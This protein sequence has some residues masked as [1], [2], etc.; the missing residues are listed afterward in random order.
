[1]VIVVASLMCVLAS[2]A[3]YDLIINT[4][5]HFLLNVSLK[6]KTIFMNRSEHFLCPLIDDPLAHASVNVVYLYTEGVSYIFEHNSSNREIFRKYF[7]RNG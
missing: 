2:A 4:V 6:N 1:M 5:G 7:K 3:V